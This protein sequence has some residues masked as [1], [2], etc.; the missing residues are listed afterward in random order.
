MWMSQL[1]FGVERHRVRNTKKEQSR[2]VQQGSCWYLKKWYQG[3]LLQL[4]HAGDRV[5][6]GQG[7]NVEIVEETAV[8]RE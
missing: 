5:I 2:R 7:D 8:D 4:M 6:D 1:L 3:R